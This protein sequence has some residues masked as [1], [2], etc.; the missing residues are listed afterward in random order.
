MP[1][2][3]LKSSTSFTLERSFAAPIEKVWAAFT[4]PAVLQQWWGPPGFTTPSADIDLRAGGK[5]RIAMKP[6]DGETLF[7]CGE[8]IEVRK[9]EK[10]VYTW[11]WEEDDGPGHQSQVTLNCKTRGKNTDVVLTQER[12]ADAESRDAHVEGWTG[13]FERL[14]AQLGSV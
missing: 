5:Y 1:E 4:E 2:A 3:L 6:P 11:A 14:A 8:F 12:L 13:S 7:L 9:P 10:L